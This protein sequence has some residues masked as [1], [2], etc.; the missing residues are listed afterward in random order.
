MADVT[1]FPLCWPVHR[2]RARHQER[3]RF[4]IPLGR[5]LRELQHEIAMLGG[6]NLI[7]SSNLRL[8]LDGIPMANQANPRDP[9]IAVYFDYQKKPMAF[10]CDRWNCVDDNVWAICK[11]IE[12]LRGINRWG[13]GSMVEQ[14]FTGFAAIPPPIAGQRPWH[15]VLDLPKNVT[16]DQA[17]QKY[18]ELAKLRHPDNGGDPA[19]FAELG[20]AIR[21]ARE[22]L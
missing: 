8:R 12:A 13:S 19:G 14:A 9:G 3:S 5:A 4:K 1:A 6:R 20:D 7:I 16:R 21:A 11:T 2:P 18:R 10:A 17:E 22:S 15:E